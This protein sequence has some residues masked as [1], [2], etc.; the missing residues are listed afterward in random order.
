MTASPTCPSCNLPVTLV[1]GIAYEPNMS[2]A[3]VEFHEMETGDDG[4]AVSTMASVVELLVRMRHHHICTAP[5]IERLKSMV[6][7]ERDWAEEQIGIRREVLDASK[8]A[9]ARAAWLFSVHAVMF[10][11]WLTL[12][13]LAT[14]RVP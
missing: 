7:T 9:E 8:A 14:S 6:A 11:L 1:D 3:L 4:E 13:G 12:M 5:A 10:V 2:P